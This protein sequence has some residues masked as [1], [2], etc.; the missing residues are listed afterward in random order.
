MR[1]TPKYKKILIKLSGEFLGDKD[2]KG[3]NISSVAQITKEIKNLLKY[4]IEISIVVG[5]GNIFRGDTIRQKE[6]FKTFAFSRVN[7][8]KAG[9]LGTIINGILLSDFMNKNRIKAK[10]LSTIFIDCVEFFDAEKVKKYLQNGYIVIFTG[11]T[12]NPYVSTD[13]ASVIKALE[14]EADVLLKATK[15]DG[16]FDKDPQKFSDAKM[17]TELTFVEAIEK[18]LRVMDL[19]A[20]SLAMENDLPIIVFNFFKRGNLEKIIQGKKVGTLIKGGKL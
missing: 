11:G 10:V 2:G 8:D 5:A 6:T 20:F 7:A 16:V 15:V 3:I 9:M 1:T 4:K 13:T 19:T 17:F 14:V 18:K 12:S